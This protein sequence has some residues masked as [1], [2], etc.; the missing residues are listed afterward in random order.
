M[1]IRS[2]TS[3]ASTKDFPRNGEGSAVLLKD[4]RILTVFSRFRGAADDAVA[5]LYSGYLD[6]ESGKITGRRIIHRTPGALNQM[7]TS[8][9][10]LQD[11]SIGMVFVRKLGTHRDL[12]FFSRSVDEGKTW[13]DPVSIAGGIPADYLVVVNDRLRQFSCGRLAVPV[14]VYPRGTEPLSVPSWIAMLYSDDNGKTWACSNPVT[15]CMNAEIPPFT[16]KS[17]KF[18]PEVVTSVYRE[19]EPGV[20]ELADGRILLY[21][22][23]LLGY[24]HYA[25]S[26]DMG[27]TWSALRP[28][29]DLITP[30]S[31]Q[32]IRRIP[33]CKRLIC[34]YN[35]RRGVPFGSEKK[36]WN[37]RTPLTLAVSDDNG[38]SW[39]NLAVIGK[40]DHN[41]CY[42]SILF[43]GD[44]VVLTVYRSEEDGDTRR[45]LAN[46]EMICLKKADLL[47][48]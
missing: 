23:T 20:E 42:A 24:M 34:L 17:Y 12:I 30:S 31:P 8:L 25:F 33:G 40:D 5:E 1:K 35:D 19:M 15:P 32:S 41:W 43:A 7:S 4:G 11:G 29:R 26:G 39:K 45:N 9:E 3:V 16:P 47:K 13:S 37:W 36:H 21:C 6:P 48:K 27:I 14:C 46:M 38:E 18:W 44:K 2:V 22:R 28:A 10:R